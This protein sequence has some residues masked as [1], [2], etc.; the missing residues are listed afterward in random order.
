MCSGTYEVLHDFAGPA[1]TIIG[2]FAAVFVTSRLGLGQLRISEQQST[3]A[4][5]QAK[6]AAVRLQDNVMALFG[7]IGA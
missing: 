3:V 7:L 1:A 6:L 2:A 4:R 5:Q